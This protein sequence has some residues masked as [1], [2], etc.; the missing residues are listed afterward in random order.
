MLSI[1][2]NLEKVLFVILA[3]LGEINEDTLCEKQQTTQKQGT[4][5]KYRRNDG[6]VI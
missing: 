2:Q 4:W 3:L 6:Y 5:R 1:D